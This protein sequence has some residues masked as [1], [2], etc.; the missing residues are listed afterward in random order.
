MPT[1]PLMPLALMA[2]LANEKT[3][4]PRVRMAIAVVAQE[5]FLEDASTP[6]NPLRFS[7]ARS[8]LS[9]TDLQ[10]AAMM[11]GLVASPLFQAAAIT[12]NSSDPAVMA[13]AVTDE[14]LLNAVRVGW[15][16]VA[17]VSPAQAAGAKETPI[18]T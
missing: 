5:V 7:L 6:G 8:V 2:A 13:A 16:A 17:G 9:P 14:Q 15:S 11:V 1:A 4:I 12:A 18:E 3:L 10:A